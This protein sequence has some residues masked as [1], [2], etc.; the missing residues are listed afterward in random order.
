MAGTLAGK[1]GLDRRRRQQAVA[2]VGDRAGGGGGRRHARPHLSRPVRRAR[3][4]TRRDADAAYRSCCRSTCRTTPRSTRCSR[5]SNRSTAG[6]TSSST[7]SRSPTATTSP[8]RSCRRRATGFGLAL[9]I[10]AYSLIA[11]AR[12]A[13]P[14][15]EARGG[16]SILTLTY[17]GSDARVPQLQ[18]D[19]GGEGGARIVGALSRR[20][21]RGA[22]HPRQRDLRRSDQDA[23]GRRHRRLLRPSSAS[24]ASA[25]RCKRTIEASR[26]GA[27]R[28]CFC[29]VPAGAAS[30]AKC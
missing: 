9:D 15:M 22:E 27:T 18:R 13:K 21:S 23:R 6:S 10:S 8:T 29:S 11:L 28:P 24:C 19:G 12:G 4:R 16:G 2:L 3:Q 7:V 25:P 1:V 20:G 30:P 17:L 26:S 5:E 14:L